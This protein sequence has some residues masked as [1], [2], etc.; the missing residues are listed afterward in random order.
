VVK[1]SVALLIPLCYNNVDKFGGRYRNE[2][3][4]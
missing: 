4:N 1:N 2:K 3:K